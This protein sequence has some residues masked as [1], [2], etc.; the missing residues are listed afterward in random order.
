MEYVRNNENIRLPCVDCGKLV[1]IP[2]DSHEMKYIVGEV[3]NVKDQPLVFC[4]CREK[5]S[6]WKSPN[7]SGES[8][9][10]R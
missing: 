2:N 8:Q 6:W 10:R 4:G 5:T 1:H 9:L 3:L 7:I